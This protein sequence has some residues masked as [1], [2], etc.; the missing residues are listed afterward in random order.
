MRID[1][2]IKYTKDRF[3]RID[4]PVGCIFKIKDIKY[5]VEKGLETHLMCS[6]CDMF[7]GDKNCQSLSCSISRKDKAYVYF[8]KIT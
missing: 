7:T 5:I 4:Y 3:D 2:V 8:K 6:K 1:P